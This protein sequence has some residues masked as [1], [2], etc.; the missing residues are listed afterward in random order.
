MGESAYQ[1]HSPGLRSNCLYDRKISEPDSA[2]GKALQAT[3]ITKGE[4]VLTRVTSLYEIFMS[5][6]IMPLIL[7]VNF[8][9]DIAVIVL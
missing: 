2:L 1:Q 4:P 6:K 8:T 5:R 7:Q 9:E 3:N